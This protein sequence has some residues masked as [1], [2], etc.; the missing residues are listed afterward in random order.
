MPALPEFK[1]AMQLE[2]ELGASPAVMNGTLLSHR[3]RSANRGPSV[4]EGDDEGN[5]IVRCRAPA[6]VQTPGAGPRS[7][8]RRVQKAPVTA[9]A[10]RQDADG[11]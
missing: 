10:T 11:L 2:N 1:G 3:S 6:S 7:L 9:N 8:A 5:G 4:D